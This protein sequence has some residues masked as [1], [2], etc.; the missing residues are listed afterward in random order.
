[1]P[2]LLICH[3]PFIAL[4]DEISI[5]VS[6]TNLVKSLAKFNYKNKNYNRNNKASKKV[7]VYTYIFFKRQIIF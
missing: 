3:T 6:N 7:Q 4:K 1:M 5:Y 2:Q